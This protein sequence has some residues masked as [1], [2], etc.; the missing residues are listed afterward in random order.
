ME[1]MN[2]VSPTR[3][4]DK[5]WFELP[6]ARKFELW[7]MQTPTGGHKIRL[8][9][10]MYYRI[11]LLTEFVINSKTLATLALATALRLECFS[12]VC[13]FREFV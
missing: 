7:L 6:R 9:Y 10:Y 3:C 11:E 4:L 12:S 5:T 8:D 1:N 13:L 2:F